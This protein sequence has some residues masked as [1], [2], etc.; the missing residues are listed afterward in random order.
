LALGAAAPKG[1][2]WRRPRHTLK[3]RQ[4]A[5][6]VA[7]GRRRLEELK[8]QAAAGAID[9]LFLDE[10]EARTHPYLAHGWAKR[11]VDLRIEAPG[12][13]KRRAML[14]AFDPIRAELLVRTSTTKRSTDFVDLLDD[15]GRTYGR[16]E[17]AKPLVVVMDNGPIHTSKRTAKALGERQWLTVEWLPKYAP[18]LNAIERCW[19]DLKRHHLANR[20]F[21]DADDLDR[22]IHLAVAMLNQERQPHSS[23]TLLKAA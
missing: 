19:R 18:E 2:T 3:G 7:A 5:A 8:R 10:A 22:I 6:A 17:R 13:A 16:S 15:L 4:D 21:A 11:G 14:G 9:L 1:F 12:Q 20:T 23:A